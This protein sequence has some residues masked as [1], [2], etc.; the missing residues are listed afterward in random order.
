MTTTSGHGLCINR[1]WVGLIAVQ[2]CIHMHV[3]L[4]ISSLFPVCMFKGLYTPQNVQLVKGA[5]ESLGRNDLKKLI[6]EY[7]NT[8]F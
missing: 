3:T 1:I 2:M 5:L 8:L 6:E 7:E 4:T